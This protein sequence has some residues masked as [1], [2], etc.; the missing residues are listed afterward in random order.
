MESKVHPDRNPGEDL[1]TQNVLRLSEEKFR[2]AFYLTPD[3]VNINR[4]VDGL[5]VSINPGVTQIM[6]YDESDV[7]GKTSLDLN[8]CADSAD[9]TRMVGRLRLHGSV[10]NLEVNF[11][12]KRRPRV[13][14]HVGRKKKALWR[15]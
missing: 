12:K 10:I 9:R 15:G 5:Y 3:S 6:E 8:I 4:L 7:I 2:K 14:A 13:W 11:A 1:A